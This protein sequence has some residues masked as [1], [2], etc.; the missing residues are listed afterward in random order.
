MAER[1][2]RIAKGCHMAMGFALFALGILLE[3]VCLVPV[4]LLARF[5][6]GKRSLLLRSINRNLFGFWLRFLGWGGLIKSLP[7]RGKPQTG[8]CVVVCNHPGLFDVLYLIRE[9]PDMAVMVKSA[10]IKKLPLAPILK[11][12]GYV[13]SEG[14]RGRD[15]MAPLLQALNTIERG[16]KFQLFPEGTRSPR[17]SIRP[18]RLGAFKI[19]R[20][21]GVPVQ[22]VFIHNHP[23]FLPHKAKWYY[24]DLEPSYIQLEYWEPLPIPAKGE[25]KKIADDLEARFRDHAEKSLAHWKTN[26]E[27]R[28]TEL[29][30]GIA[31]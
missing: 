26:Q 19:A 29:V 22:P 21:A 16:N 31:E 2:I 8:P 4:L 14:S 30:F 17:E 28:P 6:T 27:V 20:L 12:S 11:L 9:M 1:F 15:T 24:P 7:T 25:E 5:I 23:A 18:F 10:L 3:V 13:V